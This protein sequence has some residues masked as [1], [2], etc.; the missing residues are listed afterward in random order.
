MLN[1]VACAFADPGQ[2]GAAALAF[3]IDQV[4]GSEV[5]CGL[6]SK[7]SSQLVNCLIVLGPRRLGVLVYAL[8]G[9]RL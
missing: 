4:S 7:A 1:D 9:T 2:P 3:D 5:F 6:W 8:G